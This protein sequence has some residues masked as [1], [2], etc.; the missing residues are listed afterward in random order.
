M[1]KTRIIPILLLKGNSV[2]K[3]VKFKDPRVVGDAITNVKVFSSRMADEMVIVD[4]EATEKGRINES[5]IQRLAAS[6]NM[7]LSIGGGIKT[8]EDA[9]K[10][11]RSGADKVVINSSFYS[12]PDLLTRIANKY[13][14][15]SI[16]F[17]LDVIKVNSLYMPVSHSGSKINDITALKA[18]QNAIVAGAGEIIVNSIDLDG[19]MEG[20]DLE[21]VELIASNVNVPVVAAGGCGGKEDSVLAV[22]KGASAI[23]AGS[24]FYWVGESI[25]TI[26]EYMNINGITVRTI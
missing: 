20:Y 2:V 26:K 5:L 8:I 12:E 13:G 4:I 7:P 3:T 6:C 21:L 10:L 22:K 23:A 16:V 15:Q 25:I 11:F 1:I 24:I 9:D 18:A 17:S 14:I 19:T